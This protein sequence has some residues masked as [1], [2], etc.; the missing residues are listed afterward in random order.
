MPVLVLVSCRPSVVV[1][2]QQPVLIPVKAAQP[3]T[4]PPKKVKVTPKPAPKPAQEAE[5]P[6]ILPLRPAAIGG[7]A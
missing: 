7:R 2:P 1:Y 4:T 5:Q 6:I 3:A